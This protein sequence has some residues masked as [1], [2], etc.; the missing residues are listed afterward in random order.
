MM[1]CQANFVLKVNFCTDLEAGRG[2][3]WPCV[4]CTLGVELL[5]VTGTPWPN[6]T[7][8]SLSLTSFT[9]LR[10]DL[11]SQDSLAMKQ[12]SSSISKQCCHQWTLFH[13]WDNERRFT[14]L[15]W[16][17]FKKMKQNKSRSSGKPRY[18]SS[19]RWKALRHH[20]TPSESLSLNTPTDL[21]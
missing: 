2:H 13:T 5:S 21:H 7:Q 3:T 10:Q 19:W 17:P 6:Y 20:T 1:D 18:I 14:I 15:L 11:T 4:Y 16:Y 12:G 8:P 9:I